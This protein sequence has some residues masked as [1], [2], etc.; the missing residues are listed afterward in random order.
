MHHKLLQPA[1]GFIAGVL[2]GLSIITPVFGAISTGAE[3]WNG[4][5]TIVA[6]ALLIAGFALHTMR[7]GSERRLARVD[8]DDGTPRP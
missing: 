5:F 2:I 7:T 3:R 4:V 1:F 8:R 6:L